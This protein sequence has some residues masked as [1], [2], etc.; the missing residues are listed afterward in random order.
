MWAVKFCYYSL[1]VPLNILLFQ[2]LELRVQGGVGVGKHRRRNREIG[3][4]VASQ[5]LADNHV[6]IASN[7]HFH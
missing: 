4:Q 3:R 5:L 6:V 7:L 2:S 1:P